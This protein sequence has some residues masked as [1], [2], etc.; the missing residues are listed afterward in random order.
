MSVSPRLKS[1]SAPYLSALCALAIPVMLEQLGQILLGTVDT[2]FAG[3]IGDNAIAAVNVTNMFMNLFATVFTSLGIGIMVMISHALGEKDEALANRVLRQAVLA[4]TGIGMGFGV[5]NFLCRGPFLRL[6]GAEGE[7]LALGR[8]YYLVVCVPCVLMC[9]TLI[10]ANGLKAAQN[11]R[12]SMRA[13]LASNIVNAVLDALFVQVG[14]GIF[15]LGLATTLARLLNLCLLRLYCK[16]VGPLKLDRSGWR[17][18]PP[19]M[20]ELLGYSGPIM[21]TQLSARFAMLVHGS[22]VLRLGSIY[23]IANSITTT[24]DEYACIPSA[25]FEAATATMVSNS[26]GAGKPKDAA[27]YTRTAFLSTAFC[28]TFIGLILAVFAIT[29]AGNILMRLGAGYV[30][31]YVLQWNLMGIWTGIVLDFLFRGI[32][33][34]RRFF[35]IYR[36]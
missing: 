1:R 2:F 29:L 23:Y 4:G 17:P 15:G 10:L 25:G 12:A 36:L 33:L 27:R 18:D 21:C 3:R 28:M 31:A 34:G 26:L 7:I 6:A 19:L 22:L 5:L 24:I 13:A 30:L 20:K 32:L 16:D 8:T 9:L 14:L 11:A 35:K